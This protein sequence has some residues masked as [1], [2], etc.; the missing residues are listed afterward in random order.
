MEPLKLLLVDDDADILKLMTLKLSLEAHHLTIN[1]VES[2]QECLEYI[3]TN[4]VDCILSDYQMP[5]MD[6]M[7]LLLAIRGLGNDVAFIFVT[8]QGNEQVARE[9]FKN[10]ADNYFTKI[11][12]FAH[13]PKLIQSVEQ[14]AGLRKVQAE[15]KRA[16]ENLYRLNH[17]YR[18]LK[19]IHHAIIRIRDRRQLLQELCRVVVEES[20]F[21]MAGIGMVNEES[22][23]VCFVAKA[24]MDEAFFDELKVSVDDSPTGLG[25]IGSSIKTGKSCIINDTMNDPRM[26][27]W[28]E[29]MIK[30]GLHSAAG[31]PLKVNEKVIGSLVVYATLTNFFNEK[32]IAILEEMASDVSFALWTIETDETLKE[33]E[34]RFRTIVEH[35][36]DGIFV[37]DSNGNCLTV[38]SAGARMMGYSSE[39]LL[40]LSIA[41]I[42]A[43]EE[44]SHAAS[45]LAQL[46]DG[47]PLR[48]EWQFRRK[49]GSFF[50]GEV[51][52]TQMSDTRMQAFVRDITYRKSAGQHLRRTVQDAM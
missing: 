51:V 8:G 42:V 3:K 16:E 34:E 24:G 12:G 21:H 48:S 29:R 14:A 32:E 50:V 1:A 20:L 35:A 2:G 37:V 25:V 17:M 45:E 27:E 43:P 26:S 49:D 28:K 47:T 5:G 44:E 19:S 7:E 11:P 22:P 10:G 31:F 4:E 18:V 6:G 40:Q 46:K 39:E 36:P 15:K 9:A 41:D 30:W 23:Y 38:N 52:A 13:F 33:S